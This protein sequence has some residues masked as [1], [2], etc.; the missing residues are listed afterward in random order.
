MPDLNGKDLI[1]EILRE[2]GFSPPPNPSAT[3]IHAGILL[4]IL[5]E[6]RKRG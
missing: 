5:K 3:E 2:F 6:L 1:A 4:L